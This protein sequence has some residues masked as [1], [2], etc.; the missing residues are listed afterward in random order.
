MHQHTI[1]VL[2]AQDGQPVARDAF[3]DFEHR[4]VEQA[5]VVAL[6][7]VQARQAQRECRQ[8]GQPPL[9]LRHI[10]QHIGGGMQQVDVHQGAVKVVE[11]RAA[12]GIAVLD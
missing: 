2:L 12:F 3:E 6:G 10:G 5:P 9:P 11:G 8:V 4:D 7:G 1:A